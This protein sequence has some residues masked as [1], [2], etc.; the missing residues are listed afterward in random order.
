MRILAEKT[1]WITGGTGSLGNAVLRRFLH[2]DIKKIPHQRYGYAQGAHGEG[3]LANMRWGL[4]STSYRMT[5]TT[6]ST[7]N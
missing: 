5:M 2:S 7:D 1:L 4:R 6:Y 3:R